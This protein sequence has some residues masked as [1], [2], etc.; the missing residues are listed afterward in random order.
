MRILAINCGSSSIKSALIDAASGAR[1]LDLRVTGIGKP[2]AVL[3]VDGV[4]RALPACRDIGAA[5]SALLAEVKSRLG[6]GVVIE[7][8]VHR[9]VHGGERFRSPMLVDAGVTA[10]LE[11]LGRLAPLHNPPA[12]A[13]LQRA[14]EAFPGVPHVAVFDTAF[15][16]HACRGGRA[17][18][19]CPKPSAA[20][21]V[22]RYGFH[23]QPRLRGAGRASALATRRVE[24]RIVT[25]HLGNGASVGAIEYGRSVETSM[26][27]TPLEG[28]VMGTRA[29][30]VDP[31]LLLELLRERDR[32]R[33]LERLLNQ[34]IGL[35]GLSGTQRHPRHRATRRAG[36]ESCRLAIAVF[37]HRVRKYIGAYAAAMGG[38]DAIVFT[39]GIGEN[40]AL[41]A[42]PH[43]AAARV[44]GRRARRGSQPRC[45][46]RRRG[47]HFERRIPRAAIRRARGRGARDGDAGWD[48]PGG[49]AAPLLDAKAATL[50][51][52]TPRLAVR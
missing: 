34:R 2:A 38:V 31:G 49:K 40:S 33:R 10:E 24:L 22:R 41:D 46:R 27:M 18:T 25:L 48:A 26:G 6:S 44:P 51:T 7:A 1:L 23:G 30:D 52:G 29:G 12:L 28:L 19:R 9:M 11:N 17:S 21:G 3:R 39:G 45:A 15:H 37:A 47:A 4:E 42:P 35:V 50:R 14:R 16:A 8:V 5:A 13:A 43:P 32:R 36:D 20:H